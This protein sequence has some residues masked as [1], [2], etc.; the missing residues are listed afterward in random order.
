ME[1]KTYGW[2]FLSASDG[3]S[4]DGPSNDG[5]KSIVYERQGHFSSLDV[6]RTKGDLCDVIIDVEDKSFPAHRIILASTIKYFQELILNS[7][8]EETKATISV[9]DVSA[10]SMESIL[11][12]AYTG[13]ITITEE[14]AQTLLVDAD[15]LGLTDIT[16]QCIKFFY[17]CLRPSNVSQ[18]YSLAEARGIEPLMKKCKKFMVAHFED[19][20]KTD[21]Y[22]NF[23]ILLLKDI[24]SNHEIHADLEQLFDAAIRWI[25]YNIHQR[26]FYTTELLSYARL[27]NLQS[28]VVIEYFS[29]IP[30]LVEENSEFVSEIVSLY[31]TFEKIVYINEKKLIYV[32]AAEDSNNIEIYDPVIDQ[33]DVAN[34]VDRGE[35]KQEFSCVVHKRKLYIIGGQSQ[36]LGF[37][38][39]VQI[40]D[41]ETKTWT[42]VAPMHSERSLSGA[43][44]LN[45]FIYVCGGRNYS[46][47]CN[48]V[49]RYSPESNE[50]RMMCPMNICRSTL[51]VVA[52]GDAIYAIGGTFDNAPL[53]TVE[54]YDPDK[55]WWK[56]LN[57]IMHEKR[58]Q[59]GAAALNGKIYVC[60]GYNDD[61]AI[62]SV[63][64]YNPQTNRWTKLADMNSPRS[65]ALVIANMGK[66]WAIGGCGTDYNEL[67]SVEIYDPETDT[68]TVTGPMSKIKGY[69]TGGL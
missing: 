29:K 31:E 26:R 16:E 64:V 55:N 44:V 7:S 68:W 46:G 5:S 58:E 3:P 51:A 50:W 47:P 35:N 41:L 42:S 48:V 15:H 56:S 19:V 28:Q 49:E 43:V 24:F 32:V 57:S 20:C 23:D 25:T 54:R 37:K 62:S 30:S 21:E 67:S 66:I 1:A 45:D 60:G 36:K 10:Q 14:N 63:E 6:I 27:S 39:T 38:K 61:G 59:C 34:F 4:N 11:T 33:W 22:L 8:D 65:G 40:N 52:L 2:K 13:A 69:V 53:D 18:I 17:T 12:F 9:K